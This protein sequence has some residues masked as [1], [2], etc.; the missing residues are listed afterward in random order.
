MDDEIYQNPTVPEQRDN[1]IKPTWSEVLLYC[2]L[3]LVIFVIYNSSRIWQLFS[4]GYNLSEA[5]RL[6]LSE[7]SLRPLLD[8]GQYPAVGTIVVIM[9]WLFVGSIAYMAIWLTQ[10]SLTEIKQEMEASQYNTGT[11]MKTNLLKS[12]A[13]HYLTFVALSMIMVIIFGAIVM[14]VLPV[15]GKFFFLSFANLW[16]PDLQI[17]LLLIASLLGMGL[18]LYLFALSIR[19]LWRFWHLYLRAE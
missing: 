15:T 3:A 1:L 10:N 2:A 13:A 7:T 16:P 14:Y 4:N 8:F 9:F 11:S 6:A 5:D 12:I 19:V 17:Y 18:A